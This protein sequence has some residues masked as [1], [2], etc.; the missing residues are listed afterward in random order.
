MKE[1]KGGTKKKEGPSGGGAEDGI[2][3]PRGKRVYKG[4]RE[5]KK[6]K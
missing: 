1:V 6:K 3:N 5:T 4:S 2:K